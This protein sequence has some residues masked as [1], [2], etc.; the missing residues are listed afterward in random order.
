[1]PKTMMRLEIGLWVV[2]GRKAAYFGGTV[3]VFW[4]CDGV[5]IGSERKGE[6][7]DVGDLQR[8]PDAS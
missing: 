7:D 5:D 1:M 3:H 8:A 6:D 4:A 2:K